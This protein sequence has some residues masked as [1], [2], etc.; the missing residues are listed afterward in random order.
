MT[1]PLRHYVGAAI[2]SQNLKNQAYV[3]LLTL[4][5]LVTFAD[6]S[7]EATSQLAKN[8]WSLSQKYAYAGPKQTVS[9]NRFL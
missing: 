3:A 5:H 9:L 8:L 7:D 1:A 2:V 4:E 6:L